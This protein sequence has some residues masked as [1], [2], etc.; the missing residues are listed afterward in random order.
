MMF[1][2]TDPSL[3][4]S[5]RPTV[6]GAPDRDPQGVATRP[7]ILCID[8][9]PHVVEALARMLHEQFDVETATGGREGLERLERNGPFTVLVTDM[10]MPEVDGV[11]VLRVAKAIAPNTER[12]LLTGHADVESAVAAVNDGSVFRFLLKPCPPEQ[13]RRALDAAVAHERLL[14]AEREL[15]QETLKGALKLCMDVLALVHPQALA[16]AARVRRVAALLAGDVPPDDR[17][18]VEV[19]ALLAHLGA[20]TLPPLVLN[21]LHTGTT[22]TGSETRLAEQLPAL[23]AQLVSD[24]PR[25]EPVRDI[26]LYQRT[27]FDGT[28]SPVAGVAGRAIPIGARILLIADDYDVLESRNLTVAARLRVLESRAGV[29]DPALLAKLRAALGNPADGPVIDE[30]VVLRL[31]RIRFGMIFVE[32]VLGPNGITLIG[33]GQEVT[34]ALL[35]RVRQLPPLYRGRPVKM[36]PGKIRNP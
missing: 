8:D 34:D 33:R 11:E 23:G 12:I 7:R 31:D 2:D 13:M 9:E 6:T 16:R 17:W 3:D 10:R 30:S 26:L 15:L 35:E 4:L 14:R 19:A 27:W 18:C 25:L 20:V 36:L 22:L 24:I 28:N 1:T 5:S 21:K 29:Y 32:D